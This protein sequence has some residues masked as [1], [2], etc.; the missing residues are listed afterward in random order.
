MAIGAFFVISRLQVSS[1]VCPGPG[2]FSGAG[3]FARSPT[4]GSGFSSNACR[5]SEGK[6]PDGLSGAIFSPALQSCLRLSRAELLADA[7]MK[8]GR[9][10]P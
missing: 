4:P 9:A 3:A 1:E 8:K 7:K 5:N 2:G 10:C 6:A